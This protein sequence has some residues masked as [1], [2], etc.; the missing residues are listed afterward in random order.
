MHIHQVTKQRLNQIAAEVAADNARTAANIQNI[1]AGVQQYRN[2]VF[3]NVAANRS[4]ALEHSSQQFALYMG[5]QAQ[6][7]DSSGRNVILPSGSSHVWASTTG[8]TN[9]YILTDSASYNPNGQAGSAS[10]NEMQMQH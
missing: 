8:N 3:K 7:R 5:D 10:W 9:E 2:Q 1:R 4:A 6:Y